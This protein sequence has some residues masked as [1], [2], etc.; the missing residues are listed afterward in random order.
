MTAP[1]RRRP[2]RLTD[3]P[4]IRDHINR[5]VDDWPPLTEETRAGIAAAFKGHTQPI[6]DAVAVRS[7]ALTEQ[8][9]GSKDAA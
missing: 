3:I 7:A 8:A 4:R 5:I 6:K 1:D 9:G 2:A